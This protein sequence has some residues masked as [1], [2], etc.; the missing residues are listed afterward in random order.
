M[1]IKEIAEKLGKLIYEDDKVIAVLMKKG[2]VLG[3]IK[4]F[5]KKKVTFLKQ[6]SD[7]ESDYLF[8][9]ASMCS[10]SVFEYFGAQGTN[11][12]LSEGTFRA[13]DEW[14]NF[15]ILPRKFDDGLNLQWTPNQVDEAEMKNIQDL[16]SEGAFT[17]GSGVEEEKK[18][19]EDLDKDDSETI[20]EDEDDYQIKQLQRIP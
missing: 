7:E 2:A 14:L 10:V 12:L 4:I 15:D 6:L 1:E 11:I 18:E 3:H 19:P 9:I 20:G 5:P 16:L 17:I 13:D 8:S